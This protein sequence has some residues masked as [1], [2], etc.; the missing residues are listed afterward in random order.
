[1]GGDSKPKLLEGEVMP[2]W[3][4]LSWAYRLE[5]MARVCRHEHRKRELERMFESV[6]KKHGLQGQFLKTDAP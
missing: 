1:M 5:H 4:P 3:S 6:V 2:G